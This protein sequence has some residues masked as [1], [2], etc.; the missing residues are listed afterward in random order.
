MEQRKLKLHP[1][2]IF[3]IISAQSGTIGKALLELIMN[4]ID[5]RASKCEITIS[6]TGF[7]VTD[8]GRG[9]SSRREIEEFFECF[10]TPHQEGDARYGRFR[11]GRGQ[12][13]S[14]ARNTWRSGPF[15]MHVDIKD[16]GVD[17]ILT[18]DDKNPREGC[19]ITGTFYDQ[20]KPS[21]LDTCQ[22]EITELAAYAE[23]PVH[24]DGR[25]INKIP[26]SCTWDYENDEAYIKTKLTGGLKVYNLGVFVRE[27]S[28]Y[29]Y[30][31]GGTIVSKKPLEVNFA[32][33]DILTSKCPTWKKISAHL[34]SL[35]IESTDKK[36]E[37]T[38][39]EKYA[40]TR[41]FRFNQAS[42][43]DI[44]D[45]PIIE[46]VNGRSYTISQFV[47]TRKPV[48]RPGTDL[49]IAEE[50]HR[51]KLAF[52]LSRKTLEMFNC[53]TP[54]ELQK[55]IC[56]MIRR[57]TDDWRI[58][59]N[60]ERFDTH[61]TIQAIASTISSNYDVIDAK[62]LEEK[63]RL[64]LQSLNYIVSP[65]NHRLVKYIRKTGKKSKYKDLIIRAG[66][67]D[68]A[69]AWTDGRDYIV[70][71]KAKA[72]DLINHG[73]QGCARLAA[74]LLHEFLHTEPD[75]DK[76]DHDIA[77]YEEY[78][79]IIIDTPIIG[80]LSIMLFNR[81]M[82][83]LKAKGIRPTITNLKSSDTLFENNYENPGQQ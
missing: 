29:D 70:F 10:G 7:K 62:K 16:K 52:V 34:R 18:Q 19:E 51:R 42:Y 66:S 65:L 73:I 37:L 43:Q 13:M 38:E 61:T 31:I 12:I 1:E 45:K 26:S 6:S 59:H 4:S 46:D 75:T 3:K 76:H 35:T 57:D 14:F 68:V 20:L 77:F 24:L 53:D 8:D 39:H 50:V 22:R 15:T 33:T 30:G 71:D 28:S 56:E 74:L 69:D 83:L 49:R 47:A 48:V 78:H 2:I 72:L 11:I 25:T 55:A 80:D 58:L 60:A 9:F 27:Y 32:R 64:A 63:D 82:T 5:A 54:A 81:Y 79:D 44:M 23:I 21:E 40:I 41:M 36:E 17:Y 67:S